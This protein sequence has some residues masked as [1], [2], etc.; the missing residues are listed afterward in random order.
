MQKGFTRRPRPD[1][2]GMAGPNYV[3]PGGLQRLRDES[4][5]LLTRERPAVTE[6]VDPVLALSEPTGRLWRDGISA[7]QRGIAGRSEVPCNREDRGSK[8]IH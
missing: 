5:F 1:A 7:G 3:T 2:P 8:R 4:R 6:V